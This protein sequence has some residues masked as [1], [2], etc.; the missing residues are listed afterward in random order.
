MDRESNPP[1]EIAA[2][3]MDPTIMAISSGVVNCELLFVGF[4][5]V[6]SVCI[7]WS[8]E[9]CVDSFVLLIS[10]SLILRVVLLVIDSN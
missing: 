4:C 6:D 3:S 7:I 10:D 1:I 8:L 2:N 9:E 5:V